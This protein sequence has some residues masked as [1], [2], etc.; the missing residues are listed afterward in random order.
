MRK[1]LF[2]ILSATVIIAAAW[3]LW[4]PQEALAEA[5]CTVASDCGARPYCCSGPEPCSPTMP[6]YCSSHCG[7]IAGEAWR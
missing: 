3:Q 2:L 5:C 4:V 1:R 7:G 6:G